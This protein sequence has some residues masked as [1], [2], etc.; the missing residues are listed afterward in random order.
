MVKAGVAALNEYAEA[1]R[2]WDEAAQKLVYAAESNLYL[3][4][5]AVKE[6]RAFADELETAAGS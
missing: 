3:N 6:L 2:A 5:K 4:G 1:W